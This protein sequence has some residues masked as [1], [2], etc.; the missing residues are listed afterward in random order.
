MTHEKRHR[1]AH[2]SDESLFCQSQ[3]PCLRKA[4]HDYCWLLTQGYAAPSS[5]K[6]VGDKFQLKQRQR[7]MIMRSACTDI[8]RMNRQRTQC[9]AADVVGKNLYLD[10]LNVL[11]AIESALSGGFLFIGQDQCY[12][13]LASV[14]GTYKRV[15]ETQSAIMMIGNVL[16]DLKVDQTIWLLDKPVSNSGLLRQI[17]LDTAESSGW[18]WRVDLCQNPDYE[19]KQTEGTIV[20][21]DSV[22]LD[23]VSTWFH[24]NQYTI[25]RHV[26]TARLIDLR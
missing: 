24:L 18:N 17:L 25:D 12:R 23:S 5:L 8:Q 2:P 21:T 19:L 1:G 7:M 14:H 22:I 4:L 11:I 3:L 6:L 20:S 10:G 26:P 16:C 13:D 9:F 15:Q